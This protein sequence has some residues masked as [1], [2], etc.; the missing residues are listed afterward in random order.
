MTKINHKLPDFWFAHRI[1]SIFVFA[2]V[3]IGL[4]AASAPARATTPAA[5]ELPAADP[6]TPHAVADRSG[7]LD[8]REGLK[9]LL[10]ADLG[11][12]RILTLDPGAAP[13]IRY[14]VHLETDARPAQADHLLS[15]YALTAKSTP[16]GVVITSTLPPQAAAHGHSF[17]AQ[18]WVRLEIVVPRN[19]SL[20]VSTGAGDIETVDIGGAASLITQGGNIH[21]GRIGGAGVREEAG[22]PLARLETLGGHITL[23]DVAGDLVAT[24]GGGHINV[25]NITGNASLHTG[26][27]HIRAGEIGGRADLDTGDGGNI[28]VRSAAATV[29]VRTGGGQIDFGEVRGSVRAQTGGGGIRMTYVAGPLE[30]ETSGGSICLTRVA[31]S[32]R[33]TTADGTITAWINPDALSGGAV[34]LAGA[35]QLSSGSG[36]II[37]FLPRNLAATIDATV[38]SGGENGIQADSSLPIIIQRG[39]ARES[40]SA[41]ATGVLNGGGALLRL[42][43]TDGKIRLRYIDS[44]QALRESLIREQTQRI[45]EH[46]REVL[47][48]FSG[49]ME[50]A[51][52][53]MQ[54][55]AD[56]AEE[57]G[58]WFA[59]WWDSFEEKLRGGVGEDPEDLH[60]RLVASRPPVYPPLAEKAGIEGDVR[61]QV[62]VGKDGHTEVLKILEGEPILADAAITAVQQWRYK[63]KQLNGR[64]VSVISE[65][66]VKFHLR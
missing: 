49:Q 3:L 22:K 8:T 58:A 34:R 62:R 59:S 11:S 20:E 19:Y 41:R 2:V 30:V 45:N 15:Q 13:V 39:G 10:S 55:E 53:Q 4:L 57:H 29:A 23:Q 35:S 65:V 52:S 17:T 25:G 64:P 21:A 16:E 18:F 44:D 27:G 50:A 42:K 46:L 60:K 38:E 66:M 47:V 14:K 56:A 37:V 24:T 54:A 7:Q 9:L 63:P 6:G 31:G 36:D 32:V 51:R 5:V 48:N 33:A 1:F 12:V 43:T 26:G 40:G 61:L 28:T